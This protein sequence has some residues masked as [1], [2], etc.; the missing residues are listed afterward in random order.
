MIVVGNV[1]KVPGSLYHTASPLP[2]LIADNYGEMVP[3]PLYDAAT[4]P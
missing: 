2:A 1:A 3:I 4:M